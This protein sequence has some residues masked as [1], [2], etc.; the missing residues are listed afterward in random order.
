MLL[1]G[2]FIPK[3]LK[4]Q[5]PEHFGRELVLANL[6]GPVCAEGLPVSN[7][8]GECL[9]TTPF[10][11]PGQ[12]AFALAN[13]HMMDFQEE[14][15]RQTRDFLSAKGYAFAGAGDTEEEARKPMF[16]EEDGKRIAVFS[17][18]E[19][20]FGVATPDS[21]GVAAM[22]VW[23]YE[24][25]RSVKARGEADFVIVSCHAA[26][27]FCPWPAPQLRDFYHSLVD[28][29]ADVIH[30]HH[31]HVPQGWETYKDKPIFYGLGNFVVN[32]DDWGDFPHYRWS[33]VAT[34]HFE[35]QQAVWSVE[36]FSLFSKN[37][38]ILCQRLDDELQKIVDQ[39]AVAVNFPFE[40]DGQVEACWQEAACRLYP[41][42]YE[43]PLRATSC[44]SRRL[45]PRQR[46]RKLFF[47]GGDILRALVGREITTNRSIYYAKA[48]YNLFNCPSHVELIQTALGVQT[49][50]IPDLRTPETAHA[51][52]EL[53]LK[54]VL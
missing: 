13:N 4:V 38:T 29:G 17:C 49:G 21:A 11:I 54:G 47:A 35:G 52:D 9:H 42:L 46:V 19:R 7:K 6:E 33:Y 5:L 15:L 39:Y 20:Q 18:C 48:L 50:V 24:A 41:S 26:S 45:S 51:A 30:G 34:V 32:V 53:L 43:Q 2:D 27:E 36:P 14:G 25:I 10:D 16:L 37:G 22:G 1:V 23:L 31:A 28:A 40:S 3:S 44:G 8:V 12:W